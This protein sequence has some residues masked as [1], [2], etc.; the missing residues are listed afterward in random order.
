MYFLALLSIVLFTVPSSRGNKIG[1][2][3]DTDRIRKKNTN[4]VTKAKKSLERKIGEPVDDNKVLQT[5]GS[6]CRS[7]IENNKEIAIGQ[8]FLT[9][10]ETFGDM[11]MSHE[12]NGETLIHYNDNTL[13][14]GVNIQRINSFI[15]GNFSKKIKS[16]LNGPLHSNFNKDLFRSQE[17]AFDPTARKDL[18][19]KTGINQRTTMILDTM[20]F[21]TLNDI[22]ELCFIDYEES[23]EE[24]IKSK[25]KQNEQITINFD[26]DQEEIVR[27]RR[28]NDK[29][30]IRYR[31]AL[32]KTI[33]TI[34]IFNRLPVFEANVIIH[35]A[36]F[37][38]NVKER[39]HTISDLFKSILPRSKNTLEKLTDTQLRDT[40]V[41][42]KIKFSKQFITELSVRPIKLE[43]FKENCRIVKSWERT[44]PSNGHLYFTLTER[45]ENGVY[46]NQLIELLE[47]GV[48][49]QMPTSYFLIIEHYGS[50]K[51][52]IKRMK[53][54]EIISSVYSP[55][56]LSFEANLKIN[57]I[58]KN[59][60]DRLDEILTFKEIKKVN[61]F[62]E[63]TLADA[64]YPNRTNRF[65]VNFEEI[66]ID[67]VKTKHMKYKLELSNSII[68]A[69]ELDQLNLL[70]ETLKKNLGE[71]SAL[72]I[73]RDDLP[74]TNNDNDEEMD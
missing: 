21:L 73:T 52:S 72:N 36:E 63:N 15:G 2:V 29:K 49:D 64:F 40:V 16:F 20:T 66:Q 3:P 22:K 39:A 54:N 10:I 32:L 57:H 8:L 53:D 26:S 35:L 23:K 48:N 69:A 41:S 1:R 62:E 70:Q 42:K 47:R 37:K 31:A 61:E 33:T 38:N 65:N 18:K 58:A 19:S 5:L 67:E 6:V 13:N 24:I 59:E 27:K 46:L 56:K 45:H 4:K 30:I 68:K 44:I 9:G 50:N 7:L 12:K 74:F 43:G 11:L 34:K 28:T 51:A 71:E 25:L 17:D 60:E 14:N 55:T